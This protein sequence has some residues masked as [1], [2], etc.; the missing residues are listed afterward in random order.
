MN[1]YHFGVEE[2]DDGKLRDPVVIDAVRA[3]EPSVDVPMRR[4]YPVC[5][6]DYEAGVAAHTI[7]EIGGSI[8]S[9]WCIFGEEGGCK[10]FECPT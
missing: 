6:E 8:D 2:S 7:K 1:A 4:V 5:Y 9:G 10:E 3:P